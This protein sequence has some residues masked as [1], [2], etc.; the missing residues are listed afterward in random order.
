M[1]KVVVILLFLFIGCVKS[2]EKDDCSKF[3]VGDIIFKKY[4]RNP[5][6]VFTNTYKILDIQKGH[7]KYLDLKYNMEGSDSCWW[8]KDYEVKK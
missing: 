4:D 7:I 2:V 1:N 6:Y 8:V 5:F 3:K